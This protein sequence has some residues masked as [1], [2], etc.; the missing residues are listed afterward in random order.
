REA[1]LWLGRGLGVL[2]F[3]ALV[4]V[5]LGRLWRLSAA[6]FAGDGASRVVYRAALDSLSAVGVR[7]EYGESREAFARRVEG[8]VPSFGPLTGGHV[9]AR[10]GASTESG[11]VGATDPRTLYRGVRRELRAAVPL[12]RRV[13][14]TLSPWTWLF[15]R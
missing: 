3:V 1:L 7:R 8:L 13:L 4:L 11:G 5:V 15:S 2:A 12:R 10:F 6:L 9:A 14:A